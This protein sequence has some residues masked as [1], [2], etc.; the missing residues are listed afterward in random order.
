MDYDNDAAT[1][2][3]PEFLGFVHALSNE[4]LRALHGGYHLQSID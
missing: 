1:L 2:A 3:E 4:R